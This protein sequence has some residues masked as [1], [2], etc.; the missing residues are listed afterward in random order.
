LEALHAMDQGL[1]YRF[2][3]LQWP[4]LTAVLRIITLLGNGWVMAVVTTLL[5]LGLS[6]V[7]GRRAALCLAVTGVLALVLVEGIKHYVNRP[8]PDVAWRRLERLP[9]SSSFPSGHALGTMAIYLTAALLLARRIRR[10]WPA[11][12]LIAGAFVLALG[13]GFSRT[14]LGVHYPLDVLGGWLAGLGCVLL[15]CWADARWAWRPSAVAVHIPSE[16]GSLSFA[17]AQEGTERKGGVAQDAAGRHRRGP[18]HKIKEQTARRRHNS[19]ER[20][21]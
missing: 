5:V 6:A 3:S 20:G 14:Y 8:R 10:R 13:V 1:L 2:E 21:A 7:G 18:D 17:G 19:G 9:H 4:W 12:L 16:A 11:R 15:A